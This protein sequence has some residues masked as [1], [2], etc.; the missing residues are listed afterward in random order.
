M[1]Q[2]EKRQVFCEGKKQRID[3][4]SQRTDSQG[5]RDSGERERERGKETSE[6]KQIDM[7]EE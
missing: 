7:G 4:G 6:S 2:D 5:E 3:L 1:N